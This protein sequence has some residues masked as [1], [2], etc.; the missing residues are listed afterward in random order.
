M[1]YGD[2]DAFAG[3]YFKEWRK[4]IHTVA[5]FTPPKEWRKIIALDYGYSNPSAVLWIAVDHDSRA[6][7]YRELYTTRHTYDQ[8]CQ[9][10]VEMTPEEEKI[11]ALI[12]DPALQT[13]SADTG[14]SFFE[15]AKKHKFNIIPGINDRIPGW[16]VLR[17]YLEITEDEQLG[18]TAKIQ[19][20]TS[21]SALIRTLP[22]LIYDNVKVE[23]C[24]TTG[25]DHAPD[26]LRYGLVYLSKS[27]LPMSAIKKARPERPR[28][29]PLISTRF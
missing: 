10:I 24:D 3:Q 5:P 6:Y 22:T 21:C 29:T 14:V 1:L 28:S 8:L 2:W 23:D 16:N 15:I 20:S 12:A 9:K 18:G 4:E 26:A 17:K 27:L 25:E 11:E 19:I 7:V 13:K